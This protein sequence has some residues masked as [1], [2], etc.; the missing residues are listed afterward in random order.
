MV[1]WSGILKRINGHAL[2][3]YTFSEHYPFG[4]ISNHIAFITAEYVDH[5]IIL[6]TNKVTDSPVV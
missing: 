1:L 6:S 4:N 3:Q 2:L 5:F